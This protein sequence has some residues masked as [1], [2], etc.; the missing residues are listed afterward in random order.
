MKNCAD[1]T[2]THNSIVLLAAGTDWIEAGISV[3]GGQ[4]VQLSDAVGAAAQK[5]RAAGNERHTVTFTRI[6]RYATV[7]AAVEAVFSS[8]LAA[9]VS[10]AKATATFAVAGGATYT[11]ADAVVRGW[12]PRH[13]T[14]LHGLDVATTFRV[15]GGA[16]T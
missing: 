16:W 8:A 12:T 10:R 15:E 14:D 4:N 6:R 9:A 3:D 1:L 13:I 7:K 11:L 2:V 5:R